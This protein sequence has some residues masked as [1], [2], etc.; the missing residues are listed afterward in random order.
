MFDIIINARA[1]LNIQTSSLAVKV[2]SRLQELT[3]S[4]D[5]GILLTVGVSFLLMGGHVSA[6]QMVSLVKHPLRLLLTLMC[7]FAVMPA[8]SWRCGDL[9]ERC[10]VTGQ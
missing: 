2:V 7:R 4:M 1:I 3:T 5:L 8:V 10:Y 6:R 9:R